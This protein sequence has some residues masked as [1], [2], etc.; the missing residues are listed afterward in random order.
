MRL[1]LLLAG[2]AIAAPATAHQGVFG[3]WVGTYSCGQGRTALILSIQPGKAAP[4]S[5]RFHFGATADNPSVP[6][7][8]FSMEGGYHQQSGSFLLMGDAWLHQP[9]D[10]VTVDLEG[11]H[12]ADRD[13]IRG[14]VRGP[15]CRGFELRRAAVPA[16][17]EAACRA[18]APPRR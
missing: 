14:E 12:L 8:C 3:T 13:V 6:S 9:P 11:R 15:G 2:L 18:G 17:D 7:G 16:F 4:L 1:A 5:A 10:Y